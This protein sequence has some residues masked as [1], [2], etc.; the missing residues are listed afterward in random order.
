MSLFRKLILSIT[1]LMLI[2]LAGN[3]TVS[4]FNTRQY[5]GEQLTVH[6]EDTATSLGLTI[7]HAAQQKDIAQVTSMIDVIFDRGFYQTILYQGLDGKAIVTRQREI[8]IDG[9]PNWFINTIPLKVRKGRAEVISGWYRLGAIEVTV[10]PGYAYRDLWRMV[11][12]QFWLFIFTTA[13]CYAIA[14]LGLKVLLRPLDRVKRQAEAICRQ[15]FNIEERL[16]RT[17]ELREMV[18][19]INRMVSKIKATFEQQ[20]QLS[21]NLRRESHIDSVTGLPNRK[22]FDSRL[23]AWM[24]SEF[25]GAPSVLILLHIEGLSQIND[26]LGRE[27]GDRLL[28]ESSD[29]I[30]YWLQRWPDAIPARR[31][32][33]DFSIFIPGLLAPDVVPTLEELKALL[34][35]VEGINALDDSGCGSSD[36]QSCYIAIGGATTHKVCDVAT[37]LSA[38]DMGLREYISNHGSEWSVFPVENTVEDIRPAREWLQYLQN[39]LDDGALLMHYQPVVKINNAQEILHYE[40]YARIKDNDKTLVAGVF[41]PL[42]ERYGFVEQ[43]DRAVISEVLAKMRKL[44]KLTFSV[45][46]SPQSAI[47]SEF[48]SW[49]QACLEEYSD[50]A[51]RLII[52]LPEKVLRSSA[53]KLNA[54]VSLVRAKGAGVS[55]DHFGVTPSCMGVLQ[56]L[57]L[58]Y[59]KI[60]RRFVLD[61]QHHPENRFYIKSL[62]QIATSCDVK[63]LVEGIESEQDWLALKELDVVGGQG[64]YF[65]PPRETI[66]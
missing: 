50:S 63:V 49:L 14:G 39:V 26:R 4:I 25:G 33:G 45:N 53:A 51:S 22:E 7:S 40:A 46:L 57:S 31:S 23:T 55:L 38:A 36:A 5:L 16:P 2:L 9:V 6:A 52:E 41:W 34:L 32:G 8:K 21:E 35:E 42:V 10:H 29:K 47:N 61:I 15:E 20:V 60:D 43:M 11:V 65:A 37:F 1:L 30:K 27:E 12:Q 19:A 62:I 59:V 13:L 44:P 17:P 56:T 66:F 64:Y 28:I 3:A 54:F 58:H 24:N 18:V 48:Q